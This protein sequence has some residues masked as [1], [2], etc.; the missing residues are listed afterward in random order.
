MLKKALSTAGTALL[1]APL[2]AGL[3]AGAAN[4]QEA[5]SVEVAAR[6]TADAPAV[7]RELARQ[8]RCKYPEE[9]SLVGG[10]P[11]AGVECRVVSNRGR[12]TFYVLKYRNTARAI[13]FWR[14]WTQAEEVGGEP[15]YIARKGQILVIPMGGGSGEDADAYSKKWAS[16]AVDK[17]DGRL[18]P[19]YPA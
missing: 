1:F 8:M 12:Q 16:Y 15:R 13:D 2:V 4:A 19:G 5:D 7:T 6:V 11:N 18:V 10:G 9:E 17:L 3:S 14:D